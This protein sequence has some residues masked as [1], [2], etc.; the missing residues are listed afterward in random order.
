MFKRRKPLTKLQHIRELCWPSM[1]WRRSFRYVWL[2]IVRLSDSTHS[3]SKGLAI[4][5]AVAFNPLIGTHFV[6]SVLFAWLLRANVLCALVGTMAGNP[7]T[8]PFMWWAG[9]KFGSYLF[10]MIGLR[11]SETLPHHLDFHVLWD[12]LLHQPLRVLLPWTIGGFVLG[13]LSMPFTYLASYK[14]VKVGKAA[15]TK[16]KLYKIHKVALEVTKP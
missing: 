7:W 9:I 14:L 3:I 10:Y 8:Y 2:R 11:A 6:Q 5:V 4:G 1:G 13:F 16:A 12:M 15:R